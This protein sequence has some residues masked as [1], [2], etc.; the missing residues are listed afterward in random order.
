[1]QAFVIAF[2]I[3]GYLPVSTSD[4]DFIDSVKADKMKKVKAEA[5]TREE[6]LGFFSL[7]G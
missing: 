1:V 2:G 6:R 4:L 3:L 5:A 7:A